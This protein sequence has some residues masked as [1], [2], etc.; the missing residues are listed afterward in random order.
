M[1]TAKLECAV[2]EVPFK[3]CLVYPLKFEYA[4]C[5]VYAA[6]ICPTR[7]CLQSDFD[8]VKWEPSEDVGSS[9]NTPAQC[10]DGTVSTADYHATTSFRQAGRQAG[11]QIKKHTRDGTKTRHG[12][13]MHKRDCP[14]ST[15]PCRPLSNLRVQIRCK[16]ALPTCD[17]R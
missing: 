11:R 14:K 9:S 8:C 7:A 10:V 2:Q 1:Y 4:S 17:S 5:A 3:S 13:G 16:F 12:P 6:C 15:S